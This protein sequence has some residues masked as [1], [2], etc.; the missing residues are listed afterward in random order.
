MTEPPN[1]LTLRRRCPECNRWV[2]EFAAQNGLRLD[3]PAVPRSTNPRATFSLVPMGNVWI[4]G[5][6]GEI[7]GGNGHVLHEHQPETVH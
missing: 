1:P 2:L 5:H 3:W 4:A 7:T 6:G